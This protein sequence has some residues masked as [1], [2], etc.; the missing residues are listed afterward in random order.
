MKKNKN[1]TAHTLID[2]GLYLEQLN[3]S[4]DVLNVLPEFK[5]QE[6][7]TKFSLRNLPEGG[8]LVWLQ[9][10]SGRLL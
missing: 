1:Y 3:R 2:F 6:S 9:V 4:Y 8:N 10:S 7:Y 5:K